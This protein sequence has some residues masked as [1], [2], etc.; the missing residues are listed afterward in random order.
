MVFRRVRKMKGIIV[1]NYDVFG[2]KPEVIDKVFDL[3][4]LQNVAKELNV[5]SEIVNS[6]S[7]EFCDAAKAMAHCVRIIKKTLEGQVL[8]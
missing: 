2:N 6:N 5:L 7:D 1:K 8:R 3:T 4:P